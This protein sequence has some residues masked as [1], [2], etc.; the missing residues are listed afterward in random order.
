LALEW[1]TGHG[2]NTDEKVQALI[3]CFF[4]QRMAQQ[5]RLDELMRDM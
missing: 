1:E 4:E 3:F 2:N 5:R